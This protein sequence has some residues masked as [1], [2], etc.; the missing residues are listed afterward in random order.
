MWSN[1][2]AGELKDFMIDL[3]TPNRFCSSHNFYRMIPFYLDFII[4]AIVQLH[5]N[6]KIDIDEMY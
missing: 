5:V 6:I 4:S 3:I 1:L 2:V